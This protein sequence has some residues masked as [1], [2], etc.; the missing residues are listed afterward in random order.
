MKLFASV[1]FALLAMASTQ[2]YAEQLPAHRTANDTMLMP[3]ASHRLISI[4]WVPVAIN[5]MSWVYLITMKIIAKH[6]LPRYRGAFFSPS[7]PAASLANV[8]Q[9]R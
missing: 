2:S 1:A 8:D 9:R 6:S 3:S 5:L 7:P 4:I